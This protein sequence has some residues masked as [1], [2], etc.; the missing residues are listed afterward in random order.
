MRRSFYADQNINIG[1]RITNEKIKFVRPFKKFFRKK[2]LLKKKAEDKN[3]KN[4]IIIK[5][6]LI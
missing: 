5:K 4:N 1:E 6:D 2:N 3:S